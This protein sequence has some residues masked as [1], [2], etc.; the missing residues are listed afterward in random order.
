MNGT[1][2]AGQSIAV[3]GAALRLPGGISSLNGLWDVLLQGQDMIGPVPGDRFEA[4]RFVDTSMPRRGKSY[5]GVGGFLDDIS[6]FDAAY[7]GISPKEA[8]HMDP[9]HRLLLEL[10]AEALDDAAIDPAR[11]GG[12]DTAVYVGI[13]DASYGALQMSSL[14]TVGPYTMAGA[15]SSIAANR[16][17]YTFD[18]RGP[19]MAIDTACSSSLVALDHACRTLQEGTS[20]VAVCGGANVLLSPFHYVGFS[21]AAMLS[22]AGRCASFSAEA[23]GFVRAEGGG[24]VLLKRLTDALADGDRVHGVILGT[25]ANSDG[26]TM[27]MSLPSAEA[28]EDLLRRVYAQAGVHPD[29]LVYFEA[30]GTGTPVGD[31]LE[32]QA[33]GRA[34]GIRRITGDLPIGS[35]KSNLG[36]LE[37][38]SGMAGLFKALLVLRHG[39]APASLHAEPPHPD[40]DFAGLGL[41]VTSRNQPVVRVD[42]PV[43]GVNSFGFGGANAHTVLGCAPPSPQ[44]PSVTAAEDGLPVL[45]S[46]RTEQALVQAT[47]MMADHLASMAPEQFYDLAHTCCLR[48]G[49]H[50]HRAV[51]MARTPQEAAQEFAALSRSGDPDAARQ[52]HAVGGEPEPTTECR[53]A[54]PPIGSFRPAGATARVAAGGRVAFV[55]SG[56]GSQ[57]A[58]MGADLFAH[59]PDFRQEIERVDAALAPHLDWSM[60]EVFATPPEAWRLAETE[61]AQPMLFAVQA[62]LT[63][64]LRGQGIEPAMVVGHS[65][66]EVAAAYCSGAYTLAQAARVVAARSRAQGRTAGRGRMAAI[67]LPAEQALAELARQSGPLELAGVNSPQDVTVA[68][69]SAALAAFESELRGRGVFC[70]DL[71]LDYAFHSKAMDDLR[72]EL[73]TTL[74]DL[75]PG[76]VAVPFYSTVTGQRVRGADLDADYWWQNVRLPVRFDAAIRR[77]VDDGAGLLVEIGPHPV[78]RTYLRRIAATRP[79]L[80]TVVLPTLRRA[81]DGP[82]AV[83]TTLA[84][85]IAAGAVIDWRRYFP[86][87]GRVTDLPAY[88]WQRERHWSGTAQSWINSSGNGLLQHPLLGER[89][90]AP[91]PVWE[92]AIEPTLVPWLADHRISGSVIMPATGYVEMALAAGRTVLGRSVEV[93]HLDISNALV[94]PWADASAIRTQVS[95]NPDDGTLLITSIGEHSEEPRPHARARVRAQLRPRPAP[96]DLNALKKRCAARVTADAFYESCAKA[97]LVYGPTFQV[98]RNIWTGEGTAVASYCHEAPETAYTAHPALLDAALQTGVAL[99]VQRLLDGHAYLP[100]AITAVRVW[101]ELTETGHMWVRERLRS[102]DEVCWDIVITDDQ[103]QVTAQLDGCLLNRLTAGHGTPTT[104]HETVLRAAPYPDVPCA[105]S[106]LP[107]PEDVVAATSERID[108]VRTAWRHMR[109]PHFAGLFK[110]IAACHAASAVAGLLTDPAAPFT[111]DDLVTTGMAARHRGLMDVLATLMERHG[112]LAVEPDGRWRLTPQTDRADELMREAATRTPAFV[113]QLALAAHQGRHLGALLRGE[114]PAGTAAEPTANLLEQY[115]EAA[116]AH[117]FHNRLVQ[118]LVGE[119]IRDWP[120]DRTLRVLEIGAA[121]GGVTAA[122]LPMLPPERTRYTFTDPSA[123]SLARAR[124]RFSPYDFIDYRTLGLDADPA[125]QGFTHHGYDI[126]IAANSLRGT[127][128]LQAAVRRVALLLAPGGHLLGIEC[129]DPEM[130][131][132]IVGTLGGFPARTDTEPPQDCIL[133]PHESWAGLLKECGFTEVV[134]S[135]ADSEP[136]FTDHSMFLASTPR[137]PVPQPG[138]PDATAGTSFLVVTEAEGE[139][140]LARA[141]ADALTE[142]GSRARLV[143]GEAEARDENHLLCANDLAGTDLAVVLL[144]ADAG[145]ARAD[146]LVAQAARRADLLRSIAAECAR[147]PRG[148]RAALWLVTRPSGALPDPAGITHPGDAAMWAVMRCLANEQPELTGRRV[149]L[150]RSHDP[151]ADALRL[152]RE[153][154]FADGEDE[155]V[156]TVA[157]RFVPREQPLSVPRHGAGTGPFALRVHHPGLSYRLVWEE[158]ASPQPGPGQVAIDVR[159]VGLNYRDVMQAVGLL[160]AEAREDVPREVDLGLECSGVVSAC[161]PGVTVF[162]PGDRVAGMVRA[163][164][165]SSTV[166]MARSIRRIPDHMSFAEAATAPT[167][168]STIHYS[169]SHLARVQPGETV[170]VHGAAGGVGLAALQ[171][172]RAHGAEVIATAGSDVKRDFLRGLGVRHVLDSRSMDYVNE[173]REITRDQGVDVVLNSL[174]GEGITRGVELLR[175]GGRFIELGKRDMYEGKPLTL[176]PFLNNIAFYG[177][178]LTSMDDPRLVGP[179]E[180]AADAIAGSG[181]YHPLPYTVF[182]AARVED[183]FRLMQHSRHIGKVVITFDALDESPNVVPLPRALRLD[184]E[185]TYLVT[186]GNSGFG[187]ATAAW[188]ADQGA[189]HLALV[190]RRGADAPEAADALSAVADRGADAVALAVDVTDVDAMRALIDSIDAGGHPLRGIVHCAMHL[191]DAPLSELTHD[192]FAAVLAAKMGGAAILDTLTQGRNLDLFLLYSSTTAMIGNFKQSSYAAANLYLEALARQRRQR[193]ESGVAIAWGAIGETGYA[194][195]NDLLSSFQALGIEPLAPHAA[196]ATMEHLLADGNRAAEVAGITCCNWTRTGALL[197]LLSSARLTDLVPAHTDEGDLSREELLRTISLMTSEEA[198]DSLTEQLTR[199]LGEALGLDPDQLD[200]HRRLDA[201][202]MDSLMAAQVLVSLNQRYD[203]DIPPMELLRSN[204]TIVEFA[205]IVQLRLGFHT[206]ADPT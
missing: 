176:R 76:P 142:R 47:A 148:S 63:A 36:H 199:L 146:V 4:A 79:T 125:E 179:L 70:R 100:S 194:A 127:A 133:T 39:L 53:G 8:A 141:V 87:P 156:L 56:N 170:L 178:D 120:A 35:V 160:P 138:L 172:A 162:A 75:A 109:Y 48:R 123:A 29:E 130:L 55:F 136:A 111:M 191:D 23:D 145:E 113:H 41:N 89:L 67:G 64:V 21:Q 43:V 129:H 78:L 102:H 9:Q 184:P 80:T 25:G 164:M 174:A 54:Q 163:S 49:R 103:G 31:P 196:F 14:R 86:H 152:T 27:G 116:P 45:V 37:P 140:P 143:P 187:A 108:E 206:S 161:G 12:S 105:P 34:L 200:P 147:L 30:H 180:V 117:R 46:A 112:H 71:G 101:G 72:E 19:S 96:L 107:P 57:W 149:S 135:G 94:I 77:V 44:A 98:L 121:S 126:V 1:D 139:Q 24:V 154:L 188:L 15:A 52:D 69:E 134:R 205:Q 50:E 106:P 183:A 157:D 99:L 60:A 115:Q 186:G 42:R 38:A 95:L 124:S 119:A 81:Q 132:P 189:R 90:P 40:I 82:Q 110:R 58:G 5:T 151:A 20:R 173:V 65:V 185:G 68:G 88:P 22:R 85:S 104:V 171:Y 122:L 33:I 2:S 166:T 202:G 6:A 83:A 7:F 203:I 91:V 17:S 175:P 153:L 92:G 181:V 26:R 144:L 61:T 131:A 16:I 167:A 74:A 10:T 201:Y 114:A 51:V 128:D 73:T 182:P 198:L 13:S 158:M 32:A 155:I 165:G 84:S 192:R 28:Q 93:E 168:F 59:H 169:L 66:G 197:P 190:S 18:L 195:R 97:G 177:V 150:A 193:G 11:L 3:V 137:E 204:G 62:G 159:A 118:S